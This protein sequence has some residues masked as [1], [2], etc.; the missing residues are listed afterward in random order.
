MFDGAE[1]QE[2]EEQIDRV[3]EV[4]WTDTKLLLHI[5]R[6]QD[7]RWEKLMGTFDEVLLAEDSVR[8]AVEA[9]AA[10]VEATITDLKN[11]IAN[12]TAVTPEQL[13]Q[14]KAAAVVT[15]AE[16]DAIDPAAPPVEPAPVDVPPAEPM[17]GM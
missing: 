17:P 13:D 7:E 9:A 8:V 10:R 5:I 11:Q 12:G 4:G 1:L 15:A 3:Q 2:I 16:A 14:L 6:K